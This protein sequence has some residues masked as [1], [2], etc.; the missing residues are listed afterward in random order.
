MSAATTHG[1]A[2]IHVLP[3]EPA[4]ATLGAPRRGIAATLSLLCTTGILGVTLLVFAEASS[5]PWLQP[6]PALLQAVERCR[7]D[8]ERAGREACVRAVLAKAA[9]ELGTERVAQ[10]VP[11]SK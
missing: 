4:P 8:A 1:P 2:S 6:T 10:L 3:D 7:Q 9:A 11:G 5:Q